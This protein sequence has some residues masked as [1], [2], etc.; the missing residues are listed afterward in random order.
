MPER[1]LAVIMTIES[2]GQQARGIV[3]ST[4]AGK[5]SHILADHRAEHLEGPADSGAYVVSRPI[6]GQQ[7]GRE[8]GI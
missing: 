8:I 1:S 7:G 6:R 4:S 3:D 2:V 5:V